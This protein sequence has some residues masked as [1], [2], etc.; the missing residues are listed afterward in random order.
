[1][2]IWS[3][4]VYLMTIM[5]SLLWLQLVESFCI[6]NYLEDP[7]AYIEINDV[8]ASE[9]SFKKT[10]NPGSSEC[11]PYSNADCSNRSRIPGVAKHF[12]IRIKFDG[13]DWDDT[14]WKYTECETAG[15][16]AIFGTVNDHYG[17]CKMSD[18]SIKHCPILR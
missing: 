11:C 1:M 14:E 15:G 13:Q 6:Y 5:V 9:R 7:N 4:R 3:T 12:N 17:K 18:G 2:L 16:L 8:N 10:V